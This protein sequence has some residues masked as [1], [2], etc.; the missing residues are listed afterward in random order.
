MCAL[1]AQVKSRA[2]IM[3]AS[4]HPNASRWYGKVLT[5]PAGQTG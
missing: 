3:Y 2:L 1:S 5:G 4:S